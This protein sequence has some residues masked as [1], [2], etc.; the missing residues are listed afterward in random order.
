MCL[1][2]LRHE[3]RNYYVVFCLSTH[4]YPDHRI[5]TV[6]GF[7]RSVSNVF[8]YGA[9]PGTGGSWVG[10]TMDGIWLSMGH[11]G[12][13]KVAVN[14]LSASRKFP[15]WTFD[16]GRVTL[17]ACPIEFAK[18]AALPRRHWIFPC[19]RLRYAPFPTPPSGP[20]GTGSWPRGTTLVSGGCSATVSGM[21]RRGRTGNGSHCWAGAPVRSRSRRGTPGSAGRRSSCSGGCRAEKRC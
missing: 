6:R 18:T 7:W 4:A 20:G 11:Q 12:H 5:R 2:W 3:V 19:R 1:V 14:S 8:R 15:F 10:A 13:L 16:S 21:W 17:G 9:D